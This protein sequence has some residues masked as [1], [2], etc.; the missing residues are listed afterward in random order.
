MDQ[1]CLRTN[2]TLGGVK[3][4]YIKYKKAGDQFFGMSV[5]GL[6]I[7]EKGFVISPSY[8][9]ISSSKNDFDKEGKQ[10]KLNNWIK[11][12]IPA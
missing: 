4:R 2:W 8:F 11:E 1:I 5:T 7:L 9:D 6:P 10:F 12:R 3:D